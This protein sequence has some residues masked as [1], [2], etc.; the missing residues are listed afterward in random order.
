MSIIPVLLWTLGYSWTSP[1]HRIQIEHLCI[2]HSRCHNFDLT[3]CP[4]S[5]IQT[6]IT[7][8]FELEKIDFP[9]VD[10]EELR[11]M[12]LINPTKSTL[13]LILNRGEVGPKT[14]SRPPAAGS[15]GNRYFFNLLQTNFQPVT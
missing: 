15:T 4:A 7:Q 2:Q 12:L 5:S 3:R 8:H 13:L 1:Y 10:G 9:S 6:T 14:Q 11:A